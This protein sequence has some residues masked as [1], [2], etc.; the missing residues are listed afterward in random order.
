MQPVD[1]AKLLPA[2]YA[3][4]VVLVGFSLIILSADIVNPIRINQ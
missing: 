3:T 2:T 1:F 4:V